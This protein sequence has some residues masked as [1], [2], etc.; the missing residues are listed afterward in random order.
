[1]TSYH[2][3]VDSYRVKEV[4]LIESVSPAKYITNTSINVIPKDNKYTNY[5]SDAL[6]NFTYLPNSSKFEIRTKSSNKLLPLRQQELN[7]DRYEFIDYEPKIEFVKTKSTMHG[8]TES[9]PVIS[10]TGSTRQQTVVTDQIFH[11]YDF[12]QTKTPNRHVDVSLMKDRLVKRTDYRGAHELN[13]SPYIQKN[14][15]VEN[16]ENP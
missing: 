5:L 14:L 11:I 10:A 1:M 3:S 9:I 2:S 8:N 4:E 16:F 12:K 15:Y 7:F 6:N 13:P